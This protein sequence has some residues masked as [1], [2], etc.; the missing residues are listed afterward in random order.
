M[1]DNHFRSFLP[2]YIDRVLKI[3]EKLRV[4]P[5]QISVF[6]FLIAT[7]SAYLV[8]SGQFIVAAAVWWI[9]RFF[10]ACDGIYARKYNKTSLFG[11]YLDIQL[12]MA[13]YSLMII[14][15]FYNYKMMYFVIFFIYKNEK[16]HF[17]YNCVKLILNL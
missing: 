2:K 12:D 5:N 14:A 9:S 17:F 3:L 8:Y 4:T 7:G 15:F 10:D 1:I 16:I 6:A 13:A 11:A